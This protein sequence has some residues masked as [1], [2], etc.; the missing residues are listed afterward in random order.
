MRSRGKEVRARTLLL[1]ARNPSFA[2]LVT[3]SF[4]GVRLGR[5]TRNL[6]SFGRSHST[7]PLSRAEVETRFADFIPGIQHEQFRNTISSC[8]RFCPI[9]GANSHQTVPSCSLLVGFRHRP[10]RSEP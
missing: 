5:T 1:P 7:E 6:L 2:V 8:V 3:L 4:R 10:C 9:L